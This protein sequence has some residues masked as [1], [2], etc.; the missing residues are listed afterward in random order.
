MSIR[1]RIIRRC[2]SAMSV[3]SRTACATARSVRRKWPCS[4]ATTA[5]ACSSR[6]SAVVRRAPAE[7]RVGADVPRAAVLVGPEGGQGAPQHV[8]A[9]APR[10]EEALQVEVP[11]VVVQLDHRRLA[12][13]PAPADLL[14]VGVERGGRRGVQHEPHV[15]LV[16]A[17]PERR[18]GHD[19]V[20]LARPE[21]VLHLLADAAFQPG[22]VRP[23]PH[24]ALGQR[25]GDHDALLAGRAVDEPGAGQLGRALDHL[26]AAQVGIRVPVRAQVQLGPV[27]GDHHLAVLA[28]A[29]PLDDVRADRRCRGGGQ[30][31][32]RRVP[33]AF[34]HVAQ[35]QVVGPEV[36]PPLG[37][38][39]GLVDHEQ[40][41]PDRASR[42]IT[43]S[44]ASC[45]GDRNRKRARPVCDRRP[46]VGGLAGALGGVDDHGVRRVG[47]G[48]PV[49]LVALQRDQR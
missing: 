3:A 10:G 12:V 15:G 44:R 24:P 41:D 34:D 25:L 33:E 42:S 43:S 7:L 37:D 38:A 16:D 5:P 27:E 14:V 36:V 46:G 45:S 4:S 13:P 6:F 21:P 28:Q 22:V 18:G 8:G 20:H 31:G 2:R 40:P 29:E 26:A 35:A 11:G 1:E 39:V 17:H 47:L 30:R 32:H 19:H 48:E 49:A 23:R 9:R